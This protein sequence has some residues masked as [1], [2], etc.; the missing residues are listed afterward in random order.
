MKFEV[1]ISENDD[2]LRRTDLQYNKNYFD[3]QIDEKIHIEN[4]H[5]IKI[6]KTIFIKFNLR[7][8]N[9]LFALLIL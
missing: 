7:L 6:Y 1:Q 9:I 5:C 4:V 8:S 3:I 2:L